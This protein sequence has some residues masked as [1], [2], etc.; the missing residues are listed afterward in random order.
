MQ[1]GGVLIAISND[2]L[3]TPYQYLNFKQTEIA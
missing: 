2:I 3:S 1:G